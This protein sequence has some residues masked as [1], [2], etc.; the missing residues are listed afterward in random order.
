MTSFQSRFTV[1]IEEFISY[2]E[3]LGY[4]RSSYEPF[5]V[6]FVQYCLRCYPNDTVLTKQLA[7]NWARLRPKEH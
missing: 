7:M 4:S 3:A 6:Q 1:Q 5:M 2:K